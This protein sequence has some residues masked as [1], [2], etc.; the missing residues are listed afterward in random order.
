MKTTR[1]ILLS[2]WV[3]IALQTMAA[4]G[5]GTYWVATPAA[6]GERRRLGGHCPAPVLVRVP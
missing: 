2:T 4:Q 6:G 5:G 1:K 3:A